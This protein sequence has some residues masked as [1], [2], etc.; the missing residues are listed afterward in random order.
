MFTAVFH[1]P[2]T[3]FVGRVVSCLTSAV[4]ISD[5]GPV[6]SVRQ[7]VDLIRGR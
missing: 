1:V 6:A 7:L 3:A 2:V 4:V 5:P